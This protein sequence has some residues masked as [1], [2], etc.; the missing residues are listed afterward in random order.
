MT[1]ILKFALVWFIA[2][3]LPIQ[4]FAAVAMLCCGSSRI[5]APT[6]QVQ[7]E[8][9]SDIAFGVAMAGNE[10][11]G[12]RVGADDHSILKI[13][14]MREAGHVVSS[15]H[16]AG[17]SSEVCAATCTGVAGMPAIWDSVPLTDAPAL[18]LVASIYSSEFTTHISGMPQRPP[19]SFFR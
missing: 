18:T 15:K 2:L 17:T 7:Y 9:G 10:E 14:G 5:I 12:L 4:G 19:L 16:T 11:I 3:A 8:S 1:R 13:D 6:A